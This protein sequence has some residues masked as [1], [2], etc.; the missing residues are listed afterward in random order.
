[1]GWLSS[2]A[3]DQNPNSNAG[4]L[5]WKLTGN[6]AT[7]SDFVG[8]TN[9]QKLVFKCNSITALEIAPNSESKF[10]GD[11]FLDKLKPVTPLPPNEVRIVTSDNNGKLT[12]LDRSGL[13]SAIYDP[14]IQCPIDLNGL[15][16]PVWSAKGATATSGVLFT[17]VNCGAR[18]GIGTDN[19]ITTLDVN[20]IAKGV[21]FI[22]L[23]TNNTIYK[24]TFI[25]E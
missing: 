12:S 20:A 9:N 8:T 19:A 6:Q 25:K 16:V 23:T 21:Y 2:I 15:F 22:K 17:G 18:V 14:Q 10:M 11:V 24:Q 4:G 7:T 13:V 5:N 1:M 3:V